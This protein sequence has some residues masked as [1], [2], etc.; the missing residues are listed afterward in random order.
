[1]LH[2]HTDVCAEACYRPYL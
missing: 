1:V 2:S